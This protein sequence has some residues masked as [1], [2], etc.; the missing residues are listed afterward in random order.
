MPNQ[1]ISRRAFG[2]QV[3]AGA[4]ATCLAQDALAA[5]MRQEFPFRYVLGSC[6]YGTTA[7]AEILPEVKKSGAEHIDIWPARHGNQREQIDA[8]GH[9]E[10]REMLSEHGVGVGVFTRYDLGPWK[11][12]DEIAV[13]GDYGAELI[14]TGSG[15]PKDLQGEELKSAV[16]AFVEKLSPTLDLAGENGV[17]IG[18][19]NH[20]NA[21]VASPDSIRWLGDFADG[22]PLGVALAP[23]HLPQDTALLAGLIDGLGDQ[24]AHFYAW[25]H[26]MGCFE[27]L[28]KEQELMQMPGRGSLDFGP[29]L[30]AL[31]RIEFG[32]FV[33]P[34]MHPVPRGIPILDS[35][36]AVTA[37]INRARDYLA[38]RI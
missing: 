10:F 21:L 36:S 11:L 31:E 23:Y 35:T 15:G 38:S 13:A 3:A 29:L 20:G 2:V 6:M 24:L 25:E 8:M 27:K 30:E 1:R 14:V 34:F 22:K 5:A 18:I 33:E 19:E 28:P 32:G 9:A 7:L 4:A 16:K 26:G 17:T 12:A 37:E